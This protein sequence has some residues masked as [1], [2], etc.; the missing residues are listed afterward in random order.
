M[1]PGS[2][3]EAR[4][5]GGTATERVLV[6]FDGQPRS[7]QL[8]RAGWRLARGLKAPLLAATVVSR[9]GDASA[10]KPFADMGRLAEDLGAEVVHLT[11][12]DL[13]MELARLVRTRHITQI[14]IGQPER[15]P[16]RDALRGSLV[17]RLLRADAGAEL[18]IVPDR[19]P[20]DV[21]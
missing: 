17:D 9:G 5:W 11:G 3:T 13:A 1:I 8:L 15:R 7:R 20:R 2:P 16:W 12:V 19:S 18:H 4:L 14:V 10:E 6:V 21:N